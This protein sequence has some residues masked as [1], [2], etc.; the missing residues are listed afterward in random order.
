MRPGRRPHRR[1]RGRRGC[2]RAPLTTACQRGRK[3]LPSRRTKAAAGCPRA[4]GPR[5][6]PGV[7]GELDTSD[8]AAGLF[9]SLETRH[10]DPEAGAQGGGGARPVTL[11]RVRLWVRGT[12]DCFAVGK[13]FSGRCWGHCCVSVLREERES[14]CTRGGAA[15]RP[16]LG[17]EVCLECC[18]CGVAVA[19]GGLTT[20]WSRIATGRGE[21]SRWVPARAEAKKGSLWSAHGIAPLGK[22][23]AY[24][25]RWKDKPPL[26]TGAPQSLSW[27]SNCPGFSRPWVCGASGLCPQGCGIQTRCL[28]PS[29]EWASR[30]CE[31]DAGLPPE[32][33][34]G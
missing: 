31:T 16:G 34:R 13:G 11:K 9:W 25:I 29:V 33:S 4:W 21:G 5:P 19:G 28:C 20:R 30:C 7:T 17:G 27:D 10:R 2:S 22:S 6:L 8:S 3:G 1:G 15:P 18:R 24:W 32:G 23:W 14:R 12:G 26:Q